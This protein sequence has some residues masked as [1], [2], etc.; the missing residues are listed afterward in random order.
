[1]A[2]F[3][4]SK[5]HL[6]LLHWSN[7]T[8]IALH[9]LGV[10]IVNVIPNH[11]NKLLLGGKSLAIIFLA[12][13]DAPESLHRAIVNAV[14]YTRHTLRHSAECRRTGCGYI[15]NVAC[16]VVSHKLLTD[17]QNMLELTL[18]LVC[19]G[20]GS[21]AFARVANASAKAED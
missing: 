17:D 6:E 20:G 9:S 5:C 14:G 3:L 12:L 10:V 21:I 13:Q 11:S 4:R 15:R 18:C 7:N 1:M 8:R 19:G 2:D 16:T